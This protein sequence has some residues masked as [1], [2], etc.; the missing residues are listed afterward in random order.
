[1]GNK[2]GSGGQEVATDEATLGQ[3]P[4]ETEKLGK[5][6]DRKSLRGDGPEEDGLG[7]HQEKSQDAW[8]VGEVWR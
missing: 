4:V 3:S 1:M 2:E 6:I 7:A 5:Q 8:V